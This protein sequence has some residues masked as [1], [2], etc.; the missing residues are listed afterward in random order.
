MTAVQ[1][2]VGICLVGCLAAAFVPTFMRQLRLSKVSEAAMN[3]ELMHTRTAAY[4]ATEHIIARP[5]PEPA[6][7]AEG[8]EAPPPPRPLHARRCLPAAAGP[9]PSR[10]SDEPV[11]VDWQDEDLPGSATWR[12]IGFS[13]D[14]PVRYSYT[15]ETVTEG[16]GLRSPEGTYLVTFRAR[17]DLDGDG[18]R[19]VFERRAAAPEGDTGL[20]PIGIL[21]VR[22]RVE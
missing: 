17:G 8:E 16:C 15:Y 11:D 4:F 3:L 2:C 9:A 10:P 6:P 12:A 22:D 18:E 5:G 19:S 13:P 7:V 21:Y 1:V 14:R 20:I